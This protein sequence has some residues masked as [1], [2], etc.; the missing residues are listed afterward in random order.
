MMELS[1]FPEIW[2]E[3]KEG[4]SKHSS[5]LRGLDAFALYGFLT[6]VIQ[7]CYAA[8][9]NAY[10]FQSLISSICGSLGLM[11]FFIALRIHLTP[12]IQSQ[13]SHERAFI[14]FLICIS[15]LFLFVW[16]IMI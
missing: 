12:E 9:T 6:T 13:V 3:F 2:K 1:S 7:V 11:T 8:L 14:D 4:Y 5:L 16:N 15:I 10:P